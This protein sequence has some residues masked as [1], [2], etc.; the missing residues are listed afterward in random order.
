MRIGMIG[1]LTLAMTCA[2]CSPFSVAK[3]AGKEL[4]GAQGKVLPIH[5]AGRSTY[6]SFNSITL[7]QVTSD[8]G[9]LC[10]ARMTGELATAIRKQMA[11]LKSRFPG[12]SPAATVDF[13]V[14]YYDSG[15]L[16]SKHATVVTRAKLTDEANKAVSDLLV[17]STSEAMRTGDRELAD[18]IGKAFAGH[19]KDM[20]PKR[21][22]TGP[23][24]E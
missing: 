11:E 9:R 24:R 8:I 14:T 20:V 3:Q 19:L 17:V 7:G 16:I 12:G 22:A 13:A 23:K 1:A 10:P 4:I 15:G 6:A 21:A 18:A 2:G 5:S